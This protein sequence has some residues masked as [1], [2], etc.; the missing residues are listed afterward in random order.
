MRAGFGTAA[1]DSDYAP[2]FRLLNLKIIHIRFFSMTY[3]INVVTIGGEILHWDG[4]DL[5]YDFWGERLILTSQ[6]NLLQ[7]EPI[8]FIPIAEELD[9]E[10]LPHISKRY[11]I[12][13]FSLYEL[14]KI[15]TGFAAGTVIR[16]RRILNTAFGTTPAFKEMA[17][18]ARSSGEPGFHFPAELLGEANL[19]LYHHAG[20]IT[21]IDSKFYFLFRNVCHKNQ[22]QRLINESV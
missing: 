10:Q 14:K 22:L 12:R 1:N 5:F 18:Y 19:F 11:V 6:V 2:F 8:L 9:S 21:S 3:P 20:K 15:E 7:N 16:R 4:N 13:H 17:A